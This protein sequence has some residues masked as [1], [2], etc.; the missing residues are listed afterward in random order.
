MRSVLSTELSNREYIHL[1]CI[2]NGFINL[3]NKYTNKTRS[4]KNSLFS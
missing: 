2:Q 1:E 3:M 4:K